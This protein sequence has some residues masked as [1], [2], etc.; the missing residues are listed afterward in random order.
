MYFMQLDKEHYSTKIPEMSMQH[1]ASV[2]FSPPFHMMP[3]DLI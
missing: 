2:G 3:R 1:M